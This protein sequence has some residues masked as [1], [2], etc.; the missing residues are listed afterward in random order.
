M[1]RP[2]AI[3]MRWLGRQT[4]WLLVA[5]FALSACKRDAKP[6]VAAGSGLAAVAPGEQPAVALAAD[7]TPAWKQDLEAWDYPDP[8]PDFPLTDQDNKAFSLADW[9]RD[10]LLIGFVFSRC[11]MPK[12]CPLTMKKMRSVQQLW[13]KRNAAAQ[14]GGAQLR[15]LTVTLDPEFDKPRVLRAFGRGHGV[16]WS[17]WK[18]ATGAPEL[19]AEG[20]PSLFNVIAFPDPKVRLNHSVKV[21]LL[22]PG[23]RELTEWRNNDFEPAEV[24]RLV[25][26]KQDKPQA[27]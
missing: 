4:L 8:I 27:H 17:N 23:L 21:A 26:Q 22:R 25:T 6:E 5:A 20:L 2:V 16:D 10:Y 15:L 11:Q 3:V 7:A 1:S 24:V 9:G 19:V 13:A 18:L 14:G 12:A